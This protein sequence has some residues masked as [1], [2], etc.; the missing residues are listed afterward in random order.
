[1]SYRRDSMNYGT[2]IHTMESFAAFF[3]FKSGIYE[4]IWNDFQDV[5]G[6]EVAILKR[7]LI[8]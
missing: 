4:L 3:F 5:S 8:V 6:S 2:F 7:I 1:V